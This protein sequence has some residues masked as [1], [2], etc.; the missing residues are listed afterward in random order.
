MASASAAEMERPNMA[1]VSRIKEQESQESIRG[2]VKI[3][4]RSCW[5]SLSERTQ[6]CWR[7]ADASAIVSSTCFFQ[8]KL[9]GTITLHGTHSAKSRHSRGVHIV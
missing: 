6:T 4:E 3:V 5:I 2:S 1:G 8:S 7:T 9:L